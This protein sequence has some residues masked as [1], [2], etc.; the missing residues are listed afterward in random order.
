ML[1][2]KDLRVA[3]TKNTTELMYNAFK[4]V[5]DVQVYVIDE[6]GLKLALKYFICS[7][8]TIRLSGIAQM[9]VSLTFR[10][11]FCNLIKK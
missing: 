1:S 6:D 8:L 3:G 10:C 9:N 7:T 11:S 4:D 2:D 5:L